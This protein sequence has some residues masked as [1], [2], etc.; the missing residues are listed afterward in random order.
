MKNKKIKWINLP[1]FFKNSSVI[2]G[3]LAFLYILGVIVMLILQVQ[4]LLFKFFEKKG[5]NAQDW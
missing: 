3:A 2:I 4:Y 5:I 1:V